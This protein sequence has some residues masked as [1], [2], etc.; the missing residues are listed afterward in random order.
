MAFLQIH[1][2]DLADHAL[3]WWIDSYEIGM[4]EPRGRRLARKNGRSFP[5]RPTRPWQPVPAPLG[6]DL[7]HH[8]LGHPELRTPFSLGLGRP[9]VG[10]VD[11]ELAAEAGFGEA[12]SR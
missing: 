11:A 3:R 6:G 8:L 7:L 9:P 4:R 1:R 5:D 2:P 12:K 10:G